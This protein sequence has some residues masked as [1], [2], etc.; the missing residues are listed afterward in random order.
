MSGLLD[1]GAGLELGV[2]AITTIVG[3]MNRQSLL[4]S[5]AS[6]LK[7]SGSK[8]PAYPTSQLRPSLAS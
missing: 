2:W 4:V 8:A 7:R 6:R 1:V 5:V 3:S